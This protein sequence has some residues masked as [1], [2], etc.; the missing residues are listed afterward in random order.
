MFNPSV[1]GQ[2]RLD[3]LVEDTSSVYKNA[4]YTRCSTPYSKALVTAREGVIYHIPAQNRRPSGAGGPIALNADTPTSEATTTGRNYKIR[5]YSNGRDYSEG[6]EGDALFARVREQLLPMA[7]E[8]VT[9][10]A[11][12]DFFQIVSGAG[13]LADSRNVTVSDQ[14]DSEF[15]D[16]ATDVLGILE[17]QIAITGADFA[18]F[19]SD[20]ALKMRKQA[21][22]KDLAGNG[23]SSR[24]SESVFAQVL[25]DQL[26]LNEVVIGNRLYQNGS[27]FHAAN[28]TLKASGIAY[29]GVKSNLL[30]IPWSPLEADEYRDESK[31]MT[32]L[33]AEMHH[34]LVI[35]DPTLSVAFTNVLS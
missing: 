31:K 2:A 11:D 35:A 20:V 27:P 1:L 30:E 32:T 7:M 14:T 16:D 23:I 21:Q 34:D 22:F 15:D 24:L 10:D 33:R 13:V 17:D 8:Q 19:S 4:L 9:F 3:A 6:L 5:R 12:C 28:L 29:L 26:M 18:Y 25:M